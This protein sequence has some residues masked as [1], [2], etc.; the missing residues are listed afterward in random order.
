LEGIAYQATGLFT[1]LNIILLVVLIVIYGN[2]FR[3]IRA[4]FTVG[5]LFFSTIFLVQNLLALYSYI[6]MFMYYADA[7]AGF[8]MVTTFA[9]TAGLIV[10]VW[11]SLR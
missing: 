2:S 3:K 6:A 7:V 9:Q 4:Q 5:L 1:F 11:L 8:V 10:L